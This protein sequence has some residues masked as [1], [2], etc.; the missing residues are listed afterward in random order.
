M[1]RLIG[2]IADAYRGHPDV[3]AAGM[4]W[5]V[6]SG[7]AGASTRKRTPRAPPSVSLSNEQIANSSKE[8]PHGKPNAAGV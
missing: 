1:S 7:P 3:D 4:P 8:M 2:Q 5:P 6:K